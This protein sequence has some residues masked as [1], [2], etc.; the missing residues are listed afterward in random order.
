[1]VSKSIEGKSRMIL[2]P[3]FVNS[4]NILLRG[5]DH[6]RY[7]FCSFFI[8][9]SYSR[10]LFKSSQICKCKWKRKLFQSFYSLSQV[11]LRKLIKKKKNRIEKKITYLLFINF[12]DNSFRGEEGLFL[13]AAVSLEEDSWVSMET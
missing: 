11:P 4:A 12:P 3:S 7:P 10:A 8:Y 9:Q 5:S 13:P 2:G 6:C 1:M